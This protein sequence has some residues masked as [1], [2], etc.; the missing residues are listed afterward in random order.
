[1]AEHHISGLWAYEDL[2]DSLW[3]SEGLCGGDMAVEGNKVGVVIVARG[4]TGGRHI[5]LRKHDRERPASA[6]RLEVLDLLSLI[7]L[8]DHGRR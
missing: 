1:M 7:L 3:A 5:A 8:L 2:I 4:R 6:G